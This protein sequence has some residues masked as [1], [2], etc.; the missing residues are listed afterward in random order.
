M[1]TPLAHDAVLVGIDAGGTSTRARVVQDGHVIH[2][3]HGGPGNPC[4]TGIDELKTNFA[5][6][7]NGCPACP[8]RIAACVAGAGTDAMKRRVRDVL[9]ELYP[10]TTITV[11][12]DYVA[13]FYSLPE[14]TDVCVIAGTGSVICSPNED[15]SWATSEGRGWLLGDHGSAA[16][17]GRALLA[18]YVDDPAGVSE[19][20]RVAIAERFES[21]DWRDIVARVH[22]CAAPAALLASVAPILTAAADAGDPAALM[23][24]IAE[25]SKLARSTDR[26]IQRHLKGAR[27][28]NVGLVGGVWSA[29]SASS[30]LRSQLELLGSP[31][32]VHAAPAPSDPVVGAVHVASMDYR[33]V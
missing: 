7:L 4:T 9:A 33:N 12:A 14:D 21:A 3:G 1:S 23:L 24:L 19:T 11:A 13:A 30:V 32:T 27:A 2:E 5:A 17:L 22:S 31:A 18:S 29:P 16:A 15:G 10:A 8:D 6:A 26:H 25:M 28:V 20:V